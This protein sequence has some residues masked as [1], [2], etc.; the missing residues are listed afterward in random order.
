MYM[1]VEQ[2]WNAM[3]SAYFSLLLGKQTFVLAIKAPENGHV[4]VK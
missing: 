2:E 3:N 4:A 1:R